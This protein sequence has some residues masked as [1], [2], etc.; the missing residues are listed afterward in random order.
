MVGGLLL[1]PHCHH[2]V[3]VVVT[4]GLPLGI[5]G[6]GEGG[7]RQEG[8]GLG[9]LREDAWWYVTRLGVTGLGCGEL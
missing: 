8:H 1:L 9:K 2:L 5:R 3:S 7:G 4:V 6:G